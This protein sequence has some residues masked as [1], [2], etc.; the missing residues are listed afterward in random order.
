M[1]H[2]TLGLAALH[3]AYHNGAEGNSTWMDGIFHHSQALS[4]FQH[5]I[6]H[7]T[8]EISEALFVWSVCDIFYC[9]SMSNPL[10]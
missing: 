2:A 10:S 8:K 1:L 4:G 5:W 9:F 6:A 7:I 3:I